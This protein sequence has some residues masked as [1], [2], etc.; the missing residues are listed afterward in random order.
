MGRPDR[1]VDP[2]QLEAQG[3]IRRTLTSGP[4]LEEIV[5]GYRALG[6]ET[7]LVPARDLPDPGCR[8]CMADEGG[9]PRA[10]VVYT[11][12]AGAGPAGSPGRGHEGQR[13]ER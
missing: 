8:L 13:H 9:E 3:W 6:L 11:R 7:L 2:R 5:E 12:P 4:R 10:W 1:P